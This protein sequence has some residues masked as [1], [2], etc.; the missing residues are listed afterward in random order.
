MPPAAKPSSLL[1]STAT[2]SMMT[3]TLPGFIMA[4]APLIILAAASA[5]RARSPRVP[6][7]TTFTPAEGRM[8]PPICRL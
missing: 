2:P 4:M 5:T 8:S 1:V 6:S 7:L 3:V